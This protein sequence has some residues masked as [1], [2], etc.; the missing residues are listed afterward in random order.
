MLDYL[1]VVVELIDGELLTSFS[2]VEKLQKEISAK[3]HSV[4]GLRANLR[5]AEPRSIERTTGKSKRVIDLRNQ[6]E[7]QD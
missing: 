4:L 6:D 2:E 3:L 7:M 1:E 5:L